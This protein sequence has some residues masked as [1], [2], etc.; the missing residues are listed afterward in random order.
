MSAL[1]KSKLSYEIAMGDKNYPASLQ[2]LSNPPKKLYVVGNPEVFN[3]ESISIIGSR[4]ATPYGKACAELTARVAVESDLVVVSGGAIGCDQVAGMATLEAGGKHILVAGCGAHNVYPASSSYL[5]DET[6]R[7][8]GCVVSLEG[9]QNPPRRYAFPKRNKVIAALSRALIICE[10]GMPSGTFSTAE[11]AQ[12]LDREILCFPGSILSFLSKGTN[13][14][15]SEGATC[16]ADQDSLE[17]AISR[18]YSKLRFERKDACGIELKN[19]VH[20]QVLSALIA[21]PMRVEDIAQMLGEKIIKTLEIVGE[22]KIE[23]LI[24]QT[25]DGKLSASQQVLEMYTSF[26][27]YDVQ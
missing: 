19:H 8:D 3:R 6:I 4:K 12:M 17:M 27:R 22:M 15:I 10:A 1:D 25:R 20:Q 7:S 9:W 16:I 14:L 2:E 5:F 24:D 13:Y 23:G 21:N 18:I 26:G 11:T